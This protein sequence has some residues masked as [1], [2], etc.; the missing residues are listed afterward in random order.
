[1][2]VP[3]GAAIRKPWLPS[4]TIAFIEAFL[5][6]YAKR[7]GHSYKVVRG[8]DHSIA[9]NLLKVF[10]DKGPEGSVAALMSQIEK[11]WQFAKDKPSSRYCSKFTSLGCISTFWND[12]CAEATGS[13]LTRREQYLKLRDVVMRHP[14][15]S[16]T[17]FYRPDLGTLE[18]QHEFIDLKCELDLLANE[19]GITHHVW[20]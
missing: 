15:N 4:P 6:A 20:D 17:I 3:A 12:A 2:T 14:M 5:V 16:E 11:C 19:L 18:K 9:K 8:K 1:M 13:P 10:A 7:F